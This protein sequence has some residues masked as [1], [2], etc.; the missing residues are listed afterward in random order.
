MEMDFEF[1]FCLENTEIEDIKIQKNCLK[2]R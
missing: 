2:I 1:Q